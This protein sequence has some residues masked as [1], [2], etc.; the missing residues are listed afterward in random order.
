MTPETIHRLVAS[1]DPDLRE[2]WEERAGII[3]FEG[4]RTRAEAELAAF[5]QLRPKTA[6]VRAGLWEQTSRGR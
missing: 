5:E 4:N 1:W 2:S 3:E 6:P